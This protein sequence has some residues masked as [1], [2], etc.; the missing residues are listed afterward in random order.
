MA[1]H[2]QLARFPSVQRRGA[3]DWL[4]AVDDVLAL[5]GED[6]V[7]RP[8]SAVH[9]GAVVGWR[10]LSE[11]HRELARGPRLTATERDARADVA[12]V[13]RGAHALTV[14]A[15]PEPRLRT[16][17][18]FAVVDGELAFAGARRYENKSVA[19]NAGALVVRL[20]REMAADID[21]ATQVEAAPEFAL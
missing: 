7:H 3:A 14:Y 8:A 6:V 11:N 1:A 2:F 4:R 21:P 19:R 15:A 9:G 17:G 13:L 5:H 20:L 12:R 18:W 16:T 10:L